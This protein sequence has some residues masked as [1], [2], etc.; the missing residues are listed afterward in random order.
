MAW[1]TLDLKRIT[2]LALEGKVKVF[3]SSSPSEIKSVLADEPFI[4]GGGSNVAVNPS[5]KKIL[6]K[7]VNEEIKLL[8]DVIILGC[9]VN[10]SKIIKLQ[11]KK[12]FSLFEFLAGVPRATVGGSVFMNAG[13]FGSEVSD[14]LLWVELISREDIKRVDRENLSF[15]YRRSSINA[16]VWRAAFKIKREKALAV[17]NKVKRVIFERLKKHPPF[18]LKTAGSTFKNPTGQSAGRLLEFAGFKGFKVGGL[19]FSQRHA[20]FLIN[21]GSGTFRDFVEITT[22]AR[23]RVKELCDLELELEIKTVP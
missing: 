6:L 23:D 21:E 11:I 18:Y 13:A 22:A 8:N 20:N 12:G 9:S 4:L 10:I 5:T 15:S 17:K 19:K 14:K 16:L 2:T 3:F 7:P 1:K